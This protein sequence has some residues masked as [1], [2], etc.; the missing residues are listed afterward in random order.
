[1]I[2]LISTALKYIEDV[3]MENVK[4]QYDT[5]HANIEE[6]SFRDQRF[7]K[8]GREIPTMYMHVKTIEIRLVV[9]IF[10]GKKSQRLLKR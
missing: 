7:N 8:A 6:K 9:G 5:Y 4:I 1:M 2:N 3:G 10:H